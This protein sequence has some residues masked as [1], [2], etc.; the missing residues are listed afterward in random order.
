VKVPDI[1]RD[2]AHVPRV[3]L[4]AREDDFARGRITRLKVQFDLPGPNVSHSQEGIRQNEDCARDA[5]G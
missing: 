5:R 4:L 2:D 3:N 1:D